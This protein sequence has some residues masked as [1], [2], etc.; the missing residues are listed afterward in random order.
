MRL[1]SPACPCLGCD[2]VT[3]RRY[4]ADVLAELPRRERALLS[5]PLARID[6][7]YAARTLPDALSTAPHWFERRLIDHEGWG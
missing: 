4:L 5:T 2:L 6:R 3:A 1:P 7:W